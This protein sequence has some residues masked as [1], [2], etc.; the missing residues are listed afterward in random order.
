MNKIKLKSF[1]LEKRIRKVLGRSKLRRPFTDG[2]VQLLST[3]EQHSKNVRNYAEY[4][5]PDLG[6]NCT[7]RLAESYFL[8]VCN[9]IAI[10]VYAIEVTRPV[11]DVLLKLQLDPSTRDS[12]T[13]FKELF[14]KDCIVRE[15]I[16]FFACQTL[17]FQP[18]D[19][20][21]APIVFTFSSR[22]R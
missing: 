17:E 12:F 14:D 7:Y 10:E 8:Q 13:L 18:G 21:E 4:H 5:D 9:V 3:L 19:G 20:S 15:A 1:V 6:V 2:V 22:N 11:I 16:Y